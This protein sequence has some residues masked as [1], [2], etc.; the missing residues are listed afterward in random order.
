MEKSTMHINDELSIKAMTINQVYSLYVNKKL[1]VNR[2]Y[3]RKLCWTIEEKRNFI[4]TIIN[5]YPV[6]LFLLAIDENGNYEIIDGMQRLDA[7]CS[8]IEQKYRLKNGYFNLESMPD[9]LQLKRRKIIY[10]KSAVLSVDECKDIANYLL[11][12]SVFSSKDNA[13]EEVFKRINSTGKHLSLQ[14]LRQVGVNTDYAMLVRQLSSE[15]RGD[16]S[17]DILYLN[18]MSKIS[19]SNHKLMYTINIDDIFWIK[20]QIIN[21][22]D[23]RQSRDEEIIAYCL[24]TMLL[25]NNIAFNGSNLNKFYGYNRNPLSNEVPIEITSL[26]SAIDR[27]GFEQVK[28][29]FQ[30][31]ISFIKELIVFSNSTFRTLV[32]ADKSISDLSIQFNILF[33]AAYKLLILEG[34]SNYNLGL[35]LSKMDGKIH[36]LNDNKLRLEKKTQ[37]VVDMV[38]GLIEG[39]FEKGGPEDPAIDNWAMKCVNI[40]N[41]SRTEQT[42]YDFKI[43]FVQYN[44]NKISNIVL[45]KVLKTLVAINNV[46]SNKVG[47][48]IIGIAD[49]EQD[50]KKYQDLYGIEYSMEGDF[51]IVGVEHDAK[52]LNMSLDRYTHSIKELISES[53]KLQ[54]SYKQHIIKNIETPLLYNKQLIIFK[55]HF[56]SPQTFDN[57]YYVREFTDVRELKNEEIPG[58]MMTYYRNK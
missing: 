31:T 5:G 48:V 44:T 41:K 16:F 52:A 20:N 51:P 24:A 10:Q 23:L 42:L 53:D 34:R 38:Y 9:T 45:E 6:P 58:L 54:Q 19:L 30:I 36:I 35:I 55:T 14:E 15:I 32:K 17:N 50:A 3:Q 33:M 8:L 22:N 2:R 13:I 29:H 39:A 47:Y 4:D 40:L 12:V 7:I 46:G 25:G 37:G 1:I 27:V 11:P 43:G 28:I 21:S 18:D 49:N 26:Q 57:K 56:D